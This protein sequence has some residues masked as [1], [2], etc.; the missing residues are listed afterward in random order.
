M[1]DGYL[2]WKRAI[3]DIEN[4]IQANEE[5]LFVNKAFLEKAKEEV[6]KYPKPK[7]LDIDKVPKEIEGS[8]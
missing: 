4:A 5:H 1:K 7:E 8:G 3:Q 6:K 2:Y